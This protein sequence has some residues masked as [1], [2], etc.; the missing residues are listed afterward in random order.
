MSAPGRGLRKG[1]YFELETDKPGNLFTRDEPVRIVAHLEDARPASGE[2]TLKY[3][4]YDYTKAVVAQGSV[5]FTVKEDGQKVQVGLD[6]ARLGTFLFQA[7]VE[8]WEARETTFCRIPNLAAITGGKPT[9]LGFTVHAV[10]KIGFR[11]SQMIAAARRLGLTNC[12]VFTEWKSIEPGPKHYAIEH[13]DRFFE[14]A[15]RSGLQTTMTIYDPPAWV[16]PKGQSVGYQMFDCDLDALRE[17][18]TTVSTRYQGKLGG[19]EWLNE[20]TPGGPPDYVSDYVKF[21]RAGV[22]A[23]RAVDPQLASV[24]AG[25]LWPRGFRLEVLNAGAGKYVDALP[26]HYGNGSGV[27]EAREDLDSYGY[28]RVGVWENESCA[29]VIQWDCPGLEWISETDKCNWVLSQWADELAA[30]CEKLIYFGGEGAAIGYG[31]YLRADF[32]PLPVAA[33][34]AVLA[35]K[36]FDAKPVGVFSSAGKRALFHLF[37]RDGKPIL[38]ASS[39]EEAG[40]EVPLAVGTPSVRITDYQGN[41]TTLP[42]AGGVARL[43]LAPSAASSRGPTWTCSRP[44]WCPPSNVPSAGGNRDLGAGTPQIALLAGKPGGVRDPPAESLRPAARRNAAA[45]PAR[46]LAA[47]AGSKLLAATGRAENRDGAGDR[48]AVQPSG[49]IP[50][51]APSD[52]RLAEAPGG[53]QALCGLGDLAGKRRQPVAQRRLRAGRGGRQDA[54]ALARNQ[55]PARIQRGPGTGPGQARAPFQRRR[56]LGTL[57]PVGRSARRHDLPLHRLDLEPGHGGRLEHRPDH[58]RR[59]YP[60]PLQH[61]RHQ[62]RQQHALLAS[63]HLP[64]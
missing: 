29:F 2:K 35:A 25:G 62:H 43:P 54:Q 11:T 55:C 3:K 1:G 34:L 52:V 48:A 63:L 42:A 23:A 49:R 39:S 21:C 12:R 28:P 50:P 5:P 36:T 59:H 18:V 38:I 9:R 4:V 60:L 33:T 24:L 46:K 37:Q 16:M 27:Q 51:S 6:L 17:M 10:P 41:E 56:Q 45:R 22:E 26:I 15:H 7:E 20:I 57:R 31:D 40:E 13:W 14:A 30:G 44:T 61:G 53:E 64:L 58:D 8:G 32:T 47:R 19:W